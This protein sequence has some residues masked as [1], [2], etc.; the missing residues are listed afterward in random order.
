M[1]SKLTIAKQINF[2]SQKYLMIAEKIYNDYIMKYAPLC[3]E[4]DD[5]KFINV[6]CIF[7]ISNLKKKF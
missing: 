7:C 1:V 2:D 3:K 6:T 5:L 4:S